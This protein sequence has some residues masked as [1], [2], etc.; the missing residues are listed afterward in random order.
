MNPDRYIQL[1]HS[2]QS[3][4]VWLSGLSHISTPKSIAMANKAVIGLT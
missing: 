2:S 4:L 1:D 3:A